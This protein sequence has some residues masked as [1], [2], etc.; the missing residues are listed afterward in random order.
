MPLARCS[1]RVIL[2]PTAPIRLLFKSSYSSEICGLLTPLMSRTAR[3][4]RSFSGSICWL[5]G[6]KD[7]PATA[8]TVV[9]RISRRLSAAE[10]ALR[11]EPYTTPNNTYEHVSMMV[12]APNS[13]RKNRSLALATMWSGIDQSNCVHAITI[14]TVQRREDTA[15]ARHKHACSA[16]RRMR[17]S[18]G[19]PA[20]AIHSLVETGQ[21]S[22][23]QVSKLTVET[24][25]V[26]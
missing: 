3:L 9:Y 5:D 25:T 8:G 15:I 24:T 26:H 10:F 12:C 19:I 21:N 23:R 20:D 14:I 11:N 22:I 13:P 1:W 18:C 4:A 2:P 16:T 6:A 7:H 17:A